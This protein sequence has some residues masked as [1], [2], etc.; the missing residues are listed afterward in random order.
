MTAITLRNLTRRFGGTAAVDAVS[1]DLPAGSFNAL[2]GASG[3]GKTTLLRLVAG[4][5]EPDGG[6]ILFDGTPVAAPGR[7]LPPERRGVGVVFQSYALWP[8]KNVGGNIAYPLETRGVACGQIAARVEKALAMVGLGGYGERRIDELS[9]GQRQ[10]VALA[11]C[12]IAESGI[13]L[14]DEPLANLDMHLR[15][16]M[17]ETFRDIHRNTG[18]TIVYVTH[19][20]AEAL[21]LADRVAVMSK[22]RVLQFAAPREVYRAPADPV[23]AGFVGRGA[24]VSGQIMS[25]EEGMARVAVDGTDIRARISGPRSGAAR[26]LLRPEALRPAEEGLSAEVVSAT[27]RGAVHEIRARTAQGRED[28]L[29]DT[30][31]ILRPG[32]TVRLAVDDAWV[33]PAA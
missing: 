4:F 10:R 22:G 32:E 16:A 3:C 29:F 24:L 13:I 25:C 23:V 30:P 5:E 7:S 2:L 9:G 1:L 14:F 18:A 15:A 20:Q 6:E 11:R 21:A 33:V 17:I 31:G 27:Y 12:I 28:I 26:V 19:D 8:H